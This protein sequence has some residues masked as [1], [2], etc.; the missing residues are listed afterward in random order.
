MMNNKIKY[1]YNSKWFKLILKINGNSNWKIITIFLL[2][3][4]IAIN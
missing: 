2:V 3:I 1:I 4:I